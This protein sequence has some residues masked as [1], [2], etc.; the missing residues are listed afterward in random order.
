MSAKQRRRRGAQP[1]TAW[2]PPPA[3]APPP[4]SAITLF[5]PVAESGD[6]PP[7]TACSQNLANLGRVGVE[8]GRNG[9]GRAGEC[10]HSGLCRRL[11]V[12]PAKNQPELTLDFVATRRK[13][14]LHF[15]FH[16]NTLYLLVPT[17]GREVASWE[18][19]CNPERS[20][21]M[22]RGLAAL[23]AAVTIGEPP[24]SPKFP[25]HHRSKLRPMCRV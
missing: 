22:R 25:D 21:G 14:L 8:L 5:S 4:P 13:P 12:L 20:R 16:L 10:P 7:K 15:H 19:P 17:L 18:Q 11:L 2:P 24:P 6:T 9:G 3:P 23:V 1:A